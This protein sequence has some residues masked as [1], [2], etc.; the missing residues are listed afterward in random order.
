MTAYQINLIKSSWGLVKDHTSVGNLFYNRLFELAP[1][2]KKLFSVTVDTQ[3]DK[4]G[5]MLGYIIN[6]LERL[7]DIIDEVSKLARQHANYGVRPE[8]YEMG[9]EI[10]LWCLE[11]LF[12]EH[13]NEE[14]KQAWTDCYVTLTTAM[15]EA[16][17]YSRLDAA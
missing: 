16:A 12:G 9:G 1:E 7:N 17:D 11:K 8:H 4:L 3:S 13:W 2:T 5:I 15:I 14:L 10:F 6:K